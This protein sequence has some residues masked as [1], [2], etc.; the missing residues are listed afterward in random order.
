MNKNVISDFLKKYPKINY[1]QRNIRHINDKKYVE[2]VL[3]MDSNP[4]LLNFVEYGPK[5]S[6]ENIYYIKINGG[7]GGFFALYRH[8]L[9]ALAYAERLNFIPVVE[10]SNC[11]YS[12]NDKK[13][14][15]SKNPFE[16]YFEQV[17]EIKLSDVFFSKNVFLYNPGHL[18]WIEKEFKINE[19]YTCGYE[20]T[21]EYLSK[22]GA[23]AKKYIRLNAPTDRFISANLKKY[24]EMK[25]KKFW[26]LTFAG[27]TILY[28]LSTIPNKFL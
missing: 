4:N 6:D 13:I 3:N 10:Y 9:C 5:N 25:K 28:N 8:A 2:F 15:D 17:S 22:L 7:S 14:N 26:E 20:V 18:K 1:L 23:I 21:E 11:L 27:Q 19:Q 12:E 24:L 16:Y